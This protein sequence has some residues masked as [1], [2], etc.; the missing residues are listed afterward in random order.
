MSE[1]LK[2]N[3]TLEELYLGCAQ[4]QCQGKRGHNINSNNKSDNEIG[5]EGACALSEALKFNTTLETLDLE[6]LQQQ[7]Q[8]KQ[9]HQQQQIRQ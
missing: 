7:Y 9:G 3:T 6:R 4:Q 5:D 8:G 2:I 1:A